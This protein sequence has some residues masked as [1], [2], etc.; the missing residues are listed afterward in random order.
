[1][2]CFP[3]SHGYTYLITINELINRFID[4]KGGQTS[5]RAFDVGCYRCIT[6]RLLQLRE[7][8]LL[9]CRATMAYSKHSKYNNHSF[10]IERA[11][12]H[13]SVGHVKSN[14]FSEE[15]PTSLKL[16]FQ[17]IQ[18]NRHRANGSKINYTL[19]VQ[20]GVEVAKFLVRV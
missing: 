2:A 1:M 4:I 15:S 19:E 5:R 12:R 6:L 14:L 11:A 3:P 17:G 13:Q 20:N 7:R 10:F 16:R 18:R 8:S 9:H